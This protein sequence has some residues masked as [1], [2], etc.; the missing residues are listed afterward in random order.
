M[1]ALR[2]LLV[3][4][5]AGFI[6]SAFIRYVLQ[7][8]DFSGRVVN[9]D[10]L[11]YAANLDL[12]L[13]VS[14]LPR[15]RFVQGDINDQHLIEKLIEEEEIDTIVHFAAETHVDRSIASARLFVETNVLGT[16]TLL[17]SMRRN[18]A[19][20]FHHVSTDEVYGMLGESGVFNESSPC[21]PN[22]PYSASKAASDHLVRAFAHTHNISTTISH[23]SNNYGPGQYP[24]KLIPLMIHRAMAGEKLPIYGRGA[25]I[26]DWLYVDDHVRGVF[27]ILQMG[28][29]GE[30]YDMGGNC[31]L[32][33]IE[34]VHFLLETLS[35]ETGKDLNGLRSLISFVADRPGHD[36][37]YA[38]DSSKIQHELGWRPRMQIREGLAETVRWYTRQLS[39][40]RFLP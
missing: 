39:G 22:S 5:G 31:E 13:D 11:T 2:S 27:L 3:T 10:R 20:H 40:D 7:N 21:R 19:I 33:N 34:L 16:L 29:K 12:L 23:C 14:S 32:A 24:E 17:E 30:T 4:G 26:R 9:F 8:S 28:Q 1:R 38:I 25:N 35:C 37:R 15:Y 36:F 18:P 6:G